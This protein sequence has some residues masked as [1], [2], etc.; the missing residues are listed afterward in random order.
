MQSSVTLSFVNI[1]NL[2]NLILTG[3]ES[4][5]GTGNELNNV[6]TG[7][8]GNN[9]IDGAS[10]IDTLVGGLGDDTYY[11]DSL[12]D[13]ITE[14][15]NAGSD[16]IQTVLNLYSLS[17][18][19]NVENLFYSGT[20]VATLTGNALP[21][22][23]TGGPG[24]DS[25]FGGLGNDTLSG[26]GGDDH[27]VF[28]TKLNG[29]TNVDTIVDFVVGHDKID[30]SKTVFKAMGAIGVLNPDAYNSGG[31]ING[32]DLT[33]RIIYNTSTGALYYDA[34]GSGN[35]SP[36]QIAVI[37][38]QQVTGLSSTDFLITA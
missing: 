12:K 3:S 21:N 31:F 18:I 10:G 22:S 33:D 13:I 35:K 36:I 19:K 37:G 7:N 27:F 14:K 24:N 4:I 29:T 26:S 23:I 16:T 2:E 8:S 15:A 30:L 1:S 28:N 20:E 11:I 5:N 9:E 32:Q 38:T 6:I 25:V 17:K 34:D